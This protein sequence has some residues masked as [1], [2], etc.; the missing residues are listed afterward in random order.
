MTP[1]QRFDLTGRVALITGGAGIL[2]RH[3]AAT[4]LDA[5]ARVAIVDVDAERVAMTATD[6]ASHFGEAVRG[7]TGDVADPRSAEAVVAETIDRFGGV[8]ILLNNAASKSRDLQR[9]FAPFEDYD[10]D[11]WREVMAVNVDGM[12][13]MAKAVGRHMVEHHRGSVVQISSIYGVMAPDQRIYEG[14]CYMDRPINTPAVY[15]ASKAAVV[16]L[17]RYLA[18]Y[19]AEAGIR[20][21]AIAPGGME[22][23]QNET[24]QT[25]YGRRVPMGRMGRVDE[26]SG[27]VLFLASDA[28]SYVTGQTL[29]V[30]GGLSVW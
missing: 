5:G 4:L 29:L 8:D 20:V 3:F 23:G 1:A 19:W 24:F 22:S 21:N 18:A 9:F 27:A 11:I 13:L 28:S 6:L 7:L 17:T 12:F 10:P 14:S 16:G 15:S 25:N 26:L 2:G 30:D